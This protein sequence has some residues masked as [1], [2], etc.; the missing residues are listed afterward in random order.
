M[1][2]YRYVEDHLAEYAEEYNEV[3]MQFR[4]YQKQY[5]DIVSM[6]TDS[7]QQE[8]VMVELHK[9]LIKEGKE[10][11]PDYC[12]ECPFHECDVSFG[13]VIWGCVVNTQVYDPRFSC[14]GYKTKPDWCPAK[15]L[16]EKL[17]EGEEHG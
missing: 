11:I 14:G 7:E 4:D 2:D 3:K 12:S 17:K 5:P 6:L 9:L 1:K 15:E 16:C 8:V 13:I 10:K